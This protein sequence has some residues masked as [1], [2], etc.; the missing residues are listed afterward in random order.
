MSRGW[1]M[2]SPALFPI[3]VVI[4]PLSQDQKFGYLY[5]TTV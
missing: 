1:V 2:L 5:N 3:V 4:L